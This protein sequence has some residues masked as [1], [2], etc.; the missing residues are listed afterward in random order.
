[1]V[2]HILRGGWQE[3]QTGKAR[4]SDTATAGP[5][6]GQ[7]SDWFPHG[8]VSGSFCCTQRAILWPHMQVWSCEYSLMVTTQVAYDYYL[9]M[10]DKMPVSCLESY[11]PRPWKR[12]SPGFKQ[13][14]VDAS[15][16]WGATKS[17]PWHRRSCS[18]LC[19]G[20]PAC[21]RPNCS[22]RHHCAGPGI[23]FSPRRL[24][25]KRKHWWWTRQELS[26]Q[27]VW[28]RKYTSKEGYNT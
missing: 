28:F 17:D 3:I 23:F 26:S 1:M 13:G 15:V 6:L 25:I 16:L 22:P 24:K 27:L 18:A 9:Y 19:W 21:F 14:S 5:C 10:Q 7:I 8:P 12:F 4:H 2:S 11:W 20:L